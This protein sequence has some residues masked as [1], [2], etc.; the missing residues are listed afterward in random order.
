MSHFIHFVAYFYAKC[1]L[2]TQKNAKIS[3][4]LAGALRLY[5]NWGVIGGL[6]HAKR[7]FVRGCVYVYIRQMPIKCRW[8]YD[9][10]A[11]KNYRRLLP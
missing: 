1:A 5:V 2:R 8:K 7:F 4:K 9:T 6:R 10:T 3:V 11:E